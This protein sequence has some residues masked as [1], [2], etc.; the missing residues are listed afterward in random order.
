MIA[1]GTN[2]A[3]YLMIFAILSMSAN[4][5]VGYG[6]LFTIGHGAFYAVGAYTAALMSTRMGTS[7]WIELM[8][9]GL[10]AAIVGMV[11]ATTLVTVNDDYF[12]L[13]TFGFGVVTFTL[14]NNLRSFTGGS[15]GI[16]GIKA[17]TIFGHPLAT[18]PRFLVMASLLAALTFAVIRLTVASP[19][20]RALTAMR[21]DQM[22]I[23]A[24]GRSVARIKVITFGLGTGLA[25]VAGVLF[26]H[27][28]TYVDPT[29]FSTDISMLALSMAVVG[30]LGTLWGPVVGTTVLVG[31]PE[32]LRFVGMPEATGGLIRQGVYGLFLVAMLRLRP[33]G[34]LGRARR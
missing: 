9:G 24:C 2:V 32:V 30:G 11:L 7:F 3:V 28:A 27:Y 20:G 16:P 1:F 15:I 13:A 12:S 25:G 19:F 10:A 29:S 22:G 21:E 8:A 17:V 18:G 33:W 31:L 14:L 26:A 4:L 5:I 23:S 34:I 6:G